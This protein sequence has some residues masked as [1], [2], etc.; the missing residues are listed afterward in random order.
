MTASPLLHPHVDPLGDLPL[1]FDYDHVSLVPRVASTLTHRADAEP[2][3]TVGPVRLRL[4]LLGAPMPDVCG[5]EMC[6]ALAA[7]GALG[8]LHRFQPVDE[9]VAEFS[10]SH[11]AAPMT[12]GAAVG[13]T[14]DFHDRFS[15]LYGAGCRIVCLDTANGAHEQVADAM[16][17]IR[18]QADDVFIISGNVATAEAFRWLEDRGADAIRVGIAG[19]SVCETRTETA[20]YAPTPHAVAEAAQVRRRALIIG[21]S[22]VRNPA[23]MCK[24]L[25]LGADLVMVGS[26]LAGTREAP[27][28]VIVV[29]GKKVKIMRGAA[30]FSV[31]QQVGTEDP[32]YIEGTETLVPYKGGVED[33]VRRYLAGLRSSMSYMDAR[34]LEQYREN[35]SFIL[36][37]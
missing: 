4:P 12:V 30:S 14:G 3:V 6:R 21:D 10:A 25:A 15:G 37:R 24:L 5:P 32:G 33:V 19:G 27:G 29:D 34:T 7:G 20:V 11:D 18:N 2:E 22:G 28:R 35:V 31:Q 17:W 26:A 1:A 8:V 36:L 23:D 13:V 16:A 9:Q